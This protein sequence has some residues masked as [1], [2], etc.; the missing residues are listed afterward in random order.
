LISAIKNIGDLSDNP[1]IKSY[2][3]NSISKMTLE[4]FIKK[5]VNFF[6]A[7][8]EEASKE[9]ISVIINVIHLFQDLI[10]HSENEGEKEKMQNLLNKCNVTETIM[11]YMSSPNISNKIF[12]AL[13]RLSVS[14]LD[15]GN[16]FV[17][18]EIYN[19]FVKNSKSEQFFF[20]LSF[21]IN[22]EIN[23]I[24]KQKSHFEKIDIC[25]KQINYSYKLHSDFE[26]ANLLRLLQLFTENHNSNLQV[27]YN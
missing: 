22:Q 14:L 17:Q 20:Q 24:N 21:N 18:N 12:G 5:L 15:G 9:K 13:V 2:L 6:K 10:E 3:D 26:M 19:Y 16:S 1:N 25:M 8:S 4:N 23:I 27:F 7:W 11:G